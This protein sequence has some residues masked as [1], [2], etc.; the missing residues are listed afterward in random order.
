MLSHQPHLGAAPA[1]DEP[2]LRRLSQDQSYQNW[3]EAERALRE[4]EWLYQSTFEEA[5]V[6]FC[7]MDLNGRY[8]K[9]NRR[10][11]EILGYS[12]EELLEMDFRAITHPE[13]LAKDEQAVQSGLAGA[14]SRY[15]GEKRYIRKDG[16]AIW[17]SRTAAAHFG[18]DGELKHCLVAID[19]VTEQKRAEEQIAAQANLL[20]LARDAIYVLGIEGTITFWNQGAERIYGLNAANAVG[21]NIADLFGD[22]A[23]T[24][25]ARLASLQS[26]GEWHADITRRTRDGRE[27]IVNSRWTS[28]RDPNGEPKSSFV[29]ETDMTDQ[30]RLEQEFYR[31][32]RMEGIGMLASGIAHDL[33]NILTPIMMS[34]QLLRLGL[35]P[36]DQEES[37]KTMQQCAERGAEIVKQVLTF[38]R[39]VKGEKALVQPSHLVKEMVKIARETFPR[40]I[41]IESRIAPDLRCLMGDATQLHQVLMNLVVNARDAMS[42]GGMLKL[43]AENIQI[44]AQFAAMVPEATVGDCVRFRVTD[45]GM[46]IP[47]ENLN[48]LFLPFFSTKGPGKGTGLGLSTVL[49]I[50]KNH[51]GFMRV[52][53]RV[54]FG[55]T[56]EAYVPACAESVA[57]SLAPENL[58]IPKGGG[59][60]ILV[61]E[62][63][64]SVRE[65]MRKTLENGGYQVT[66]ASDGIDGFATFVK[67]E[68]GFS[69][70]LTDIMMPILDGLAFAR[71]IRKVSSHARIIAT[72]GL[73]DDEEF[74]G[75]CSE[76]REMGV[77]TILAKPYSAEFLL[78]EVSR[79]LAAQN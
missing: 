25:T 6:G 65:V 29:I 28:I 43:E 15:Q 35:S 18:R 44:D 19:D 51:G 60:R 46:G 4:S 27:V 9:V 20:N 67:D 54:G 45:S 2:A 52:H 49:G 71:A 61:V 63:E 33:N 64:A 17:C 11:C 47:P 26:K 3:K 14:I 48:K 40:N 76:L 42:G 10:F 77:T 8:L 21:R 39:G 59:Q 72:S 73:A 69:L 7:H 22:D 31:A 36:E 56:F 75:K 62:D 34:V 41:R 53:S 5:P 74:A 79:A 38:G 55:S 66:T 50:V 32:Q 37:L 70:V 30:K 68:Q 1:A 78:R 23:P 24:A 12:R 57:A 13:D 16:R 58:E